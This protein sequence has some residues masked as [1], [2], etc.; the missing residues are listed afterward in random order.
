MKTI[1]IEESDAC[2]SLCNDLQNNHSHY[3]REDG[4]DL[5]EA[6][7]PRAT[8]T[9]KPRERTPRKKLGLFAEASHISHMLDQMNG[10]SVEPPTDD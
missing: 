10:G 3:G 6:S 4:R 5:N 2:G 9:P 7:M 8:R 1:L